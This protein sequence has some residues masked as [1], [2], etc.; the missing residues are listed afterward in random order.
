MRRRSSLHVSTFTKKRLIVLA[1][2]DLKRAEELFT[3]CEAQF[4]DAPSRLWLEHA[5]R[6]ADEAILDRQIVDLSRT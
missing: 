5:R 4:G 6:V 2:G 3:V 1:R